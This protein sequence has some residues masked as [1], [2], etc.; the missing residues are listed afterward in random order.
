MPDD[1]PVPRAPGSSSNEASEH[2]SSA[3]EKSSRPSPGENI[4]LQGTHQGDTDDP[5]T[6]NVRGQQPP[7]PTARAERLPSGETAD[8]SEE[9]PGEAPSDAESDLRTYQLSHDPASGHHRVR[10]RPPAEEAQSPGGGFRELSRHSSPEE[11][12]EALQEQ[13]SEGPRFVV[14][15]NTETGETFFDREDELS[16]DWFA[17]GQFDQVTV[18]ENEDDAAAY[19]DR[20]EK[21]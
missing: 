20:E 4:P 15:E 12:N 1:S 18:F 21:E 5:L 3:N 6:S 11:M 2:R 8:S 17:G 19:A 9:S 10:L 14:L 16:D 7:D 13:L